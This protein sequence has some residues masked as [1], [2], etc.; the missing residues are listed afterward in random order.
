MR[1]G[2]FVGLTRKDFN[3]VNNTVNIEKTWDYKH[4]E[5]FG[6]TKNDQSV[7]VIDIDHETMT[8]FKNLFKTTPTNYLGLVF[9]SSQSSKRV[10]TNE[11]VN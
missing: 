2:E 4:D 1:F 7:R 5:G 6:K 11:S 9:F 10:L 3:F 8:K